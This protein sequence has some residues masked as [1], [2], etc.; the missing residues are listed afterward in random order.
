MIS[1]KYIF[2]LNLGGQRKGRRG[3]GKRGR[4]GRREKLGIFGKV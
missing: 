2:Q 3:E 1:A 4:K